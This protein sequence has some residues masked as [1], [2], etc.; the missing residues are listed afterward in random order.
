MSDNTETPTKRKPGAPPGRRPVVWVCSAI[1]HSDIDDPLSKLVL[2]TEKHVVQ[3]QDP[4]EGKPGSF[5]KEIAEKAFYDK[6]KVHAAI[7]LGPFFDKRG[8]SIGKSK[9]KRLH[10]DRDNIDS[11]KI[12]EKRRNAIFGDWK[13]FS[14][15]IEGKPDLT[16][17]MFI[18]EANPSGKKRNL[19]APGVVNISDVIFPDDNGSL[20]LGTIGMASDHSQEMGLI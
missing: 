8:A 7:T 15:A 13:G 17:F 16:F 2:A 19:P 3:D 12:E 1:K 5:P 4:G 10:I 9:R 14:N 6:H 11:Y 20:E 18:A